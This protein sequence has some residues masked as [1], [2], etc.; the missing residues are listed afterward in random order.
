[1][2]QQ[3]RNRPAGAAVLGFEVRQVA[4]RQREVGGEIECAAE[5]LV[6]QSIVGLSI[7]V[8]LTVDTVGPAQRVPLPC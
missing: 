8:V 3:P 7:V 2:T 4:M 1:M 5:G 6:G